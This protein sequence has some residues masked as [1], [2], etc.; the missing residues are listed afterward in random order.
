MKT[1]NTFYKNKEEFIS[2]VESYDID[3]TGNIFVQIFCGISET[4]YIKNLVKSVKAVLP[5]SKI[6]GATT[7]GEIL[8]GEVSEHETVVSISVFDKTTVK[9]ALI[10]QK[11]Q[12]AHEMGVELSNA[13]FQKD[14][15]VIIAFIGGKYSSGSDWQECLDGVQSV[16]SEI[17]LTGGV[18]G[19]STSFDEN[20][21]LVNA[22]D[23]YY[24]FTENH[25]SEG[26]A[27]AGASLSGSDLIVHNEYNL[28]W[29]KIGK[30]M[31]ITKVEN[32]G[33]FTRVYTIDDIP[34][35]NIYE[36]YFGK[37]KAASTAVRLLPEFSAQKNS[38]MIS[39]ET[40]STLQAEWNQ[41]GSLAEYRFQKPFMKN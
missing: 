12:T 30:K 26:E 17:I 28:G 38:H 41:A 35:L 18:A 21:Q 1:Y 11:K 36:K 6:L 27:I 13:V 23:P 15:K 10:S 37:D 8:N 4:D 39:G 2:T 24:V 29:E 9:T 19:N 25:I 20:I 33:S 14:G 3:K 40:Q 32:M 5:S 16:D 22:D 7:C 31:R 34:I